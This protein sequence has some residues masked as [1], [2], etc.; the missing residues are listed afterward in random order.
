[1]LKLCEKNIIKLFSKKIPFRSHNHVTTPSKWCRKRYDKLKRF[2]VHYCLCIVLQ[3]Q[4]FD[5]KGNNNIFVC[6]QSLLVVP[7]TITAMN[8]SSPCRQHGPLWKMLFLSNFCTLSWYM[9]ERN[10]RLVKFYTYKRKINVFRNDT[11][12]NDVCHKGN[13]IIHSNVFS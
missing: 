6:L 8:I 1:M 3:H 11:S 9:G 5:L 2:T 10:T 12:K 7:S 13:K 4:K